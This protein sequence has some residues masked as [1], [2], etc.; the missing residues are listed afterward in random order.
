MTASLSWLLPA[1]PAA[2]APQ[3]SVAVAD[4]ALSKDGGLHGRVVDAH[5]APVAQTPVVIRANGVDVEAVTTDR[6]G[7]FAASNL[8]GGVYQLV[9]HENVQSYRLWAPGTAPPSAPSQATLVAGAPVYRGQDGYAAPP[10]NTGAVLAV[11]LVVTA[12]IAIPIAV[13]NAND[14]DSGS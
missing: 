6:N 14:D 9:A 11:G 1:A 2:A 13:S 12:A 8:R 3:H 5:G 10:L 4:V 7:N